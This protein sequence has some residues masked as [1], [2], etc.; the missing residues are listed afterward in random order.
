LIEQQLNVLFLCKWY[1]SK[2]DQYDGNF[3]ENHAKAVSTVSELAVIF[4]HSDELKEGSYRLEEMQTHGF[5]EYRCFYARSPFSPIGLIRYFKAQY[6]AYKHYLLETGKAP[7]IVHVHI[8][9][10]STLLALYLKF[11]KK[12]PFIISEHW[13][14]Y[15]SENGAFKGFLRK[16]FYRFAASQASFQTAV[17]SYLSNSIQQ[18]NIRGNFQLIPNVVDTATFTYRPKDKKE[19]K[20]ILH[21]SNLSTHPKNMPLIIDALSEVAKEREDFTFTLVG[22]GA[23]ERAMLEKLEKSNLKG[24]YHFLGEITQAAVARELQQADFLLLYSQYETQSCVMI[25]AFASGT[26][27][28]TAAVGGIP[29]YMDKSRGILLAPNE[30]EVLKEGIQ[31]MLEQHDSFA[32]EDMRKYAVEQF[33]EAVIAK[34]FLALYKQTL[35]NAG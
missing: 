13:S 8:N 34:A 25:E 9:G 35:R 31:K 28:L 5:P 27:V 16:A 11:W 19:T 15:T 3:I 10:R 20:N 6:K 30:K 22:T 24:R 32:P 14:G 4:A 7:D 26:P 29:E 21:I 23:E 2:F 18:H 12:I 17:S 1:P 33:S